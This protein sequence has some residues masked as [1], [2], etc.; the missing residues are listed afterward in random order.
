MYA[1]AQARYGLLKSSGT[2]P[3][4]LQDNSIHKFI[5]ARIA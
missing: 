2:S 1:A 3:K 4:R 5:A